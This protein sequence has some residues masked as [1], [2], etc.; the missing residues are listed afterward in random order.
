MELRQLEAFAHVAEHRSFTRVAEI[1]QTNQ[2]ALSR[3]VRQLEV[4]LH[5]TLLVRNGRVDLALH[6]WERDLDSQLWGPAV[7]AAPAN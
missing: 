2:P 4:E 1:L 3:L 6:G 5:Q 7:A